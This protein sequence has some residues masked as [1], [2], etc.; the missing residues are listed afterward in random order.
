ML[1]LSN[2]GVGDGAVCDMKLESLREVNVAKVYFCQEKDLKQSEAELGRK[3]MAQLV[4]LGTKSEGWRTEQ[5][6]VIMEMTAC[7]SFPVLFSALCG[8]CVDRSVV[9]LYYLC[10]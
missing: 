7:F 1:L 3:D 4:P 5:G 6:F 9:R 10:R 2:A 8:M